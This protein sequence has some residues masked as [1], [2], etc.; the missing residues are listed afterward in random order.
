MIRD[1]SN[2]Y[3]SPEPTEA[4]AAQPNDSERGWD[5]FAIIGWPI[6]LGANLPIPLLCGIALTELA[7]RWG[8]WL[9]ILLILGLG[10]LVCY[11][12]PRLSRR[13]VS[14]SLLVAVTQFIP[15]LQIVAGS[16]ALQVVAQLPFVAGVSIDEHGPERI[17]SE[18][19]GF[20]VTLLVGVSLLGIVA[21]IIALLSL[22]SARKQ[23]LDLTR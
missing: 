11:N 14:A 17:V 21:A 5:K 13:L 7:G 9:A 10:Y 18:R 4:P 19:A 22:F 1:D 16:I 20:A 2:P 15:I 23:T 12:W 3:Q 8:M 6:A